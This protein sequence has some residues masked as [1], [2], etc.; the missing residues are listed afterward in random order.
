M[1]LV[2]KLHLQGKE[3]QGKEVEGQGCRERAVKLFFL[4]QS[5]EQVVQAEKK[6][7]SKELVGGERERLIDVD[8]IGTEGYGIDFG[9]EE[10]QIFFN[11]LTSFIELI[12]QSQTNVR[13]S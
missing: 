12:D 5:L 4:E 6:V 7:I 11:Y 2:F 10:G 9:Q 3:R 13:I 1:H 8:I